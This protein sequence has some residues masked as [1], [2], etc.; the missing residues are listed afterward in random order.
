VSWILE[1]LDVFDN[2]ALVF[3]AFAFVGIA[4]T[5]AIDAALR[6]WV[7]DE[8][9]SRAA[10]T[11]AWVLSVLATIYA[12]LAAFVIVDEYG[13]LDSTQD[14]VS[15]KAAALSSISE[16]SRAFPSDERQSIEDAAVDYANEVVDV[17]FP[18][19][20]EG[21]RMPRSTDKAL[22]DLF[23]VVQEIEPDTQSQYAFYDQIVVNLDEVVSTRNTLT[24]SSRQTVPGAL[25]AV[26]V[27]NGL[28]I[29]V[30][31]SLLDTQHR[32]SHLFILS[33]LALVI[34][35]SLALVVSLDQPFDGVIRVNDQPVVDFIDD[36]SER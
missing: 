12:V 8:V 23:G 35:L 7:P 36:R 17:G 1:R 25:V 4:I 30:I 13:Q 2:G 21:G 10:G 14:A 32:R 33:A 27:V 18:A 15:D 6:R 24:T 19:L 20:T 28:T 16:N 3:L 22:E 29:L 26:L 31:A 11:A 5:I 34:S 9:R